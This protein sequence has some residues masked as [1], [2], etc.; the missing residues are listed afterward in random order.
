M[1]PKIVLVTGSLSLSLLAALWM[2][3][4]RPV[5]PTIS[6]A[7]CA[8]PES[9]VPDIAQNRTLGA[10]LGYDR[11]TAVYDIAAHTVYLPD[12]TKL[13]AHSGLGDKL[14]DPR[15]VHLRKRGATPPH[16]YELALR[17]QLFHGVQALRLRPLGDG[18]IFGRVGLLAH[19][20]MLGPRGDSNG[21]VVFKDYSAFLRAFQNGEIKRL[22]VIGHLA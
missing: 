8:A 21:C 22:A 18:N 14:D 3:N 2:L 10:L 4:R 20:Y 13:E 12:G 1:S 11:W 17:E 5:A 15:Y 6:Q 7:P 16:V 19:N 9:S